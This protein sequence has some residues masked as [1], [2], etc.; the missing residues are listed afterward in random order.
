MAKTKTTKTTKTSPAELSW[1]PKK[2]F[3]L[4]FTIPWSEVKKTYDQTLDQVAKNTTVKGFR[5]GKAPV[6]VVEKQVDQQALFER[7]L[8]QLLPTYF[9]QAVQKHQLRPVVSPKIQVLAAEQEKDWQFKATAC[10]MP[11]VKVKDFEK[12]VKGALAESDIWTPAKG[13]PDQDKKADEKANQS[14]KLAAIF[15]ALAEEIKIEVPDMLIEDEVNRKLSSL[16]AQVE[17]L[18]LKLDQYLVS[19][20]KTAEQL[21][22]DYHA[23]AEETLKLELI[24]QTIA[25]EKNLKV[26]DKEIDQM[27][28]AAQDENIKKKL[29]TPQQKA[30]IRHT[31]LK[32]KVVDFLLTL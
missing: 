27:I 21:R 3:E 13:Q 25:Q 14:Q 1:L 15:K 4:T 18:G 22:K 12:I 9:S 11:E 10:E 20:G 8:N 31:L 5:K 28:E 16:L 7:V 29:N 24:L 23:Q 30:Y 26:E 19:V 6:S 2:T 32:Q 17:K